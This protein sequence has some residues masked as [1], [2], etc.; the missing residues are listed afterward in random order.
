M[1]RL[2]HNRA[3]KV[4]DARAAQCGS[5]SA[6]E[7]ASVRRPSARWSSSWWKRDLCK[8]EIC[9]DDYVHCVGR[10]GCVKAPLEPFGLLLLTSPREKCALPSWRIRSARFEAVNSVTISLA[11]SPIISSGARVPPRL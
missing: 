5:R 1:F 9:V 11:N 7:S 4:I 10:C 8:T 6:I 2:A 3:C